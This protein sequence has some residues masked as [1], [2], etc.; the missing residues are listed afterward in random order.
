MKKHVLKSFA[1][2]TEKQASGP[3]TLLKRY[4]S[5]GAFLRNLQFF[6][7]HLVSRTLPVAASKNNE[8]Q[9]LSKGRQ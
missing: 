5:I 8:Q 6:K 3:M 4:S 9:Q 2:F 7:E 1:K